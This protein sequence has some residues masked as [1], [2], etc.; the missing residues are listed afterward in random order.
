MAK[1]TTVQAASIMSITL[2]M[3]GLDALCWPLLQKS[4]EMAQ[5]LGLFSP[6]P[7]SDPIW[8]KAAAITSWAI[9]NW[10]A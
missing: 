7:E 1:I 10:Q 3:N 9:F 6:S 4:I 8:E 5:Q 2:T